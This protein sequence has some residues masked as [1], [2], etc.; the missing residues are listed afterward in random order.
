MKGE[1]NTIGVSDAAIL[2]NGRYVRRKCVSRARSGRCT[3]CS[4]LSPRPTP[5]DAQQ[6]SSAAAQSQRERNDSPDCAA[7]ADRDRERPPNKILIC[8]LLIPGASASRAEIEGN[9][10]IYPRLAPLAALSSGSAELF[11]KTLD[12]FSLFLSRNILLSSSARRPYR[13]AVII[14][15]GNNLFRLCCFLSSFLFFMRS[16]R[17]IKNEKR[18]AA[19]RKSLVGS[20]QTQSGERRR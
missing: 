5:A 15:Y 20:E 18:N 2:R 1:A 9:I 8:I 19:I 14:I 4:S 17:K 3:G 13:D 7:I 10:R 16:V 6:P 12:L 11:A